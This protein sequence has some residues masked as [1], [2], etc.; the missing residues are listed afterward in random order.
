MRIGS[1]LSLSFERALGW[2]QILSSLFVV[3]VD[4]FKLLPSLLSPSWDITMSGNSCLVKS[5]K[6]IRINCGQKGS[7]KSR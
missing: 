5:D 1:M 4:D 6:K 2:L 3:S 7:K